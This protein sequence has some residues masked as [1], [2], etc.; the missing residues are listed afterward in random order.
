MISK[1]GDI[2]GILFNSDNGTCST[3]ASVP[4]T[5]ITVHAKLD[6]VYKVW[7]DSNPNTEF[8]APVGSDGTYSM[9]AVPIDN[10]DLTFTDSTTGQVLTPNLSCASTVA[11]PRAFFYGEANSQ[12]D[13]TGDLAESFGFTGIG[14]NN[15]VSISGSG[16]W[17]TKDSDIT[18][19]GSISSLVPS[20]LQ[21]ILNGAG[22]FPGVAVYSGT[23]SLGSGVLSSKLWQANTTTRNDKIYSFNS[24]LEKVPAT[25]T[26]NTLSSA[27]DLTAI[28]T[29][30]AAGTNKDANGYVWFK[31]DG[32]SYGGAD[33][34]LT[35]SGNAN[36]GTNKIVIMVANANITLKTEVNLT[37]GYGFFGLFVNGDI[38]IDPTV[39]NASSGPPSLEGIYFADGVI[40]TG[41]NSFSGSGTPPANCPTGDN[42]ANP[43]DL[44]KFD[45][46]SGTTVTDSIDSS[47]NGTWGGTG[48][49]WTP[50]GRYG[51]A[52]IFNGID[53][54]VGIGA[55]N[56][57]AAFTISYWYWA[58]NNTQGGTVLGMRDKVP[59]IGHRT[60]GNFR[61]G[62][63]D[64]DGNLVSDSSVPMPAPQMWHLVTVTRT[65]AGKLNLYVDA[66]AA[67]PLFNGSAEKG[68][69][70]IFNIGKN[71]D[72]N[73]GYFNGKLDQIKVYNYARTA[74]EIA[75]DYGTV[76]SNQLYVRGSLAGMGGVNLQRV[77][78]DNTTIPAEYFEYAP[79]QALLL[80]SSFS[81]TKTLWQEMAP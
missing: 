53:D 7:P 27:A 32:A 24:F 43:V 55:I 4:L 3:A 73:S 78:T 81:A 2:T 31:Y 34:V 46:G 80:P 60:N 76:F 71:G 10:Y 45:E 42:C 40:S 59:V 19:A 23:L 70:S 35:A 25:V 75:N 33:L 39:G 50:S 58:A 66:G 37:K 38:N 65:S 36:I 22:G 56:P 16:W 5:G 54:E 20:G 18:A 74:A 15:P 79:D 68:G 14:N 64:A 67:S 6:P 61:I 28:I 49:H 63:K 69:F 21:F 17:Q 26:F 51:S 52:A 77:L 11:H 72:E 57:A 13:A 30:A 29:T 48:T 62:V 1:Y 41:V 9:P 12:R 44:Y 47:N 8:T